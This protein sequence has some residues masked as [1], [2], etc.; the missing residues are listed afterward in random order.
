MF[1]TGKEKIILRFIWNHKR[2]KPAKV[3]LRKKNKEGG[4]KLPDF[5]IFYKLYGIGIKINT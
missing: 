3:I 4:I 1:F 5:K 2:H